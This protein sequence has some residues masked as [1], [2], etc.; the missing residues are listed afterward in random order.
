MVEKMKQSLVVSPFL[1]PELGAD[2]GTQVVTAL[3][4]YFHVDVLTTDF[5]HHRK[6]RVK[7]PITDLRVNHISIPVIAYK[8]NTGLI[9]IFSHIQFMFRATANLLATRKKYDLVYCSAPFSILAYIVFRINPTAARVLDIVDYWPDSLPFPKRFEYYMAPFFFVWRRVNKLAIAR[10]NYVISGSTTFLKNAGNYVSDR[11][12]KKLLYVQLFDSRLA[13]SK[14]PNR[15]Y[16]GEDIVIAFVGNMGRLIDWASILEIP[17]CINQNVVFRLVGDG[18]YREVLI[19]QLTRDKVAFTYHGVVYDRDQLQDIF[20]DA[21]F[22][23]NGYTNTNASFSYK[24]AVYISLGLPVLNSTEGDLWQEIQNFSSG[25]NFNEK[26]GLCNQIGNLVPAGYD[27]LSLGV[28]EHQIT[29]R[30]G[31]DFRRFV[32]HVLFGIDHVQTHF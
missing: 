24:A 6:K 20:S 19:R 11:Y 28:K 13:E 1:S 7:V 30:E 4:E 9:R 17:R 25:I 32:G 14:V 8:N 15:K 2:R 29:L 27:R 31:M 23:Y 12:L 22:G 16:S 21:H 26:K 18:D 5:C 3:K 10:A